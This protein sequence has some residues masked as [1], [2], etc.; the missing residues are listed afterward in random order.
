MSSEVGI[1]PS[2]STVDR[3]VD[4]AVRCLHAHRGVRVS[5]A[6]VA[7]EAGV[8][9]EVAEHLFPDDQAL[10]EAIGS[11]GIMKLSDAMNR[12]LVVVAPGDNRAA[13]AA[14]AC[15]YLLW[16]RDNRDL[17]YVLTTQM[18]QPQRVNSIVRK[19]DA[20]FVTLVRRF[21]GESDAAPTRRAAIARAFLYGFT[22]LALDDHLELWM[23]PHTDVIAELRA[24]IEDF[25]DILLGPAPVAP[26][27]APSAAPDSAA[28]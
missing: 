27:V 23:L 16:A 11:F 1:T 3:M 14:I 8:P 26:P 6:E 10:D 17:Y 4:A 7:A 18:M 28:P 15:S 21:L 2:T 22:D 24:T 25:I 12:A 20:S 9:Q 19:Y 5:V 13:L